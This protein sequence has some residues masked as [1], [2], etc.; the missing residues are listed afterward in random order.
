MKGTI[1]SQRVVDALFPPPPPEPKSVANALKHARQ[2]LSFDRT[3]T[4]VILRRELETLVEAAQ[5]A[6]DSQ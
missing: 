1:W 6:K 3:P 2:V 5:A 4:V